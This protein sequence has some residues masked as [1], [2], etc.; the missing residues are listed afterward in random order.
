MYPLSQIGTGMEKWISKKKKKV[1]QILIPL[2]FDTGKI[3]NNGG[4][5]S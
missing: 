3:E 4:K 1:P 2:K 5:P